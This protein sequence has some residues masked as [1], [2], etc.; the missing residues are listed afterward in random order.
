MSRHRNFC[1]T[2]NNY[3]NTDLEDH[4]E[5]RYIGYSK[6][7]APTT[8]TLHLQGWISFTN[9]RTFK[10]VVKLMPGCHIEVMHG[11]IAQNET[12]CSKSDVLIE[13]GEKP[14]TNDNKG[15]AEQ[16]RW[17]EAR[18]AACEGRMDD[19]PD[20]MY[21]RYFN[22]WK[23]I[24]VEEQKVPHQ[25]TTCKH[26]WIYGGSGTGKTYAARMAYPDAYLKD[27]GTV[28]WDGYIGQETVI[29]EDVDKFQHPMYGSFKRWLDEW[30]FMAQFKGGSMVIRPRR[31]IITSNYHYDD[32]WDDLVT[33]ECMSR[34][35]TTI[36][37][38]TRD[39][40]CVFD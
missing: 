29:I 36:H 7:V 3:D 20:D 39:I 18:K 9:A 40:M 12:Y 23:K 33:R 5:C 1:F 34:R 38:M 27:P 37:K 2:H 22:T 26:Y 21:I 16:L 17:K 25:L 19:I 14:M 8:G 6:E 11:S 24:R 13:R 35:V 31:I 32:I 15:R 4:I 28:W 30:S 10:Q